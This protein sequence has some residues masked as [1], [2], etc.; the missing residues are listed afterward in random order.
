MANMSWHWSN[1]ARIF[2][3]LDGLDVEQVEGD[4]RDESSVRRA[5][6]G[7]GSVFH[8][9]ALYRFWARDSRA[10]Y[11][12]N[13]GGT[14][15]VLAAARD[16]GVE[17][18]VYTSTVGTLGLDRGRPSNELDYPDVSHLFGSYKRSK[19]V[20]EHEALRA[21][22]EGLP[23]TIVLPTYPLGPGD[24][25][26]TPSGRLILDY[27]NGKVPGYVDT[28]LNPVHVD[29]VARGQI[30]AR[31]RGAVGRS[32]ILGSENLTTLQ[33]LNE[34]AA[35]SGLPEPRWHVPRS[36]ALAAAWVSDT[37]EG[38]PLRRTPRVPL[39]AARMSSTRMEFD[40]FRGPARSWATSRDR[41]PRPS[42]TRRG[43]YVENGYVTA[44]RVASIRWR[45]H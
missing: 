33:L 4:L 26:P 20:A 41:Q 36:A 32:Y 9:A 28:V 24:R 37:V 18:V 45:S 31:E 19:Y 44:K 2:C 10:F 7:C 30:L 42:R 6:T 16:A 23:V 39:E 40:D 14:R 17:R 22:A 3:G 1:R 5:V 27:L 25:A 43:W 13:V 15:A 12:I 11:D 8:V 29:D 35:P 34:L 38:R 21:A